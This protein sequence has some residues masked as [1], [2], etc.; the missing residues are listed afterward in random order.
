LDADAELQDYVRVSFTKNHPM[1]FI[2]LKEKRIEYP[3]VLAISLEVVDFAGVLF[4]NQNAAKRT[5]QI[6]VYIFLAICFFY[7][8]KCYVNIL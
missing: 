5:T 4:S 7:T 3:R 6:K 1:M 2:A 8:R